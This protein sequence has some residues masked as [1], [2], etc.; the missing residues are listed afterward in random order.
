MYIKEKVLEQIRKN[1]K[2]HN[3]VSS[4]DVIVIGLSGGADSVTLLYALNEL[5]EEFGYKLIAAHVNHGI[6]EEA[7]DDADFCK[8]LCEKL[9]IEYHVRSVDIKKL[10]KENRMGEEEMGRQIRYGFFRELCG[11]NGKIATAHN[12]NDNV[13]TI[14][15]RLIR[16]TGLNGLAGISF[17][18]GNI[19]RP[20]LNV[21]REDIEAFVVEN[22][23]VHVTDKTN[24]QT[25][26]T[27]NKIR[28]DVIPYIKENINQNVINTIGDNIEQ[29]KEDGDCLMEIA[30][31]IFNEVS[32]RDNGKIYVNVSALKA[33]HIAL[34]KRVIIK[35]IQGVKQVYQDIAN[36]RNIDSILELMD[37]ENGKSFEMS[38]IYCYMENGYLVF[39]GN[40]DS[41]AIEYNIEVEECN[42]TEEI[43]NNGC[44]CYVPKEYAVN[45]D[46][47][48][49]KRMQGDIVRI[50][51][52]KHKKLSSFLTDKKV[53]SDIRKDI[54][55]V[56]VDNEIV[57]IPGYF[58]SRY[59]KRTGDFI[60]IKVCEA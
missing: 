42:M 13:E 33:K 5:K 15:M 48:V 43:V 31:S 2:K 30:E 6:R 56:V 38:G 25:I 27:R 58:G 37:K 40:K 11:E 10:A 24:F 34:Q 22:G 23:L 49:R 12:K 51:D 57:M 60:K 14:F 7:Q 45:K 28:L 41:N 1:I 52:S 54:Q 44:V 4:G 55:V 26:Y 32:R 20:I 50:D 3:M 59:N 39:A 21:S 29:Y 9:D 53:P 19:I 8:E 35:A 17:V 36:A 16:G 46:I 47:I 18:N